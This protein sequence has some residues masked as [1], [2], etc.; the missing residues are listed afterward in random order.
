[1]I[2]SSYHKTGFRIA[3]S[4]YFVGQQDIEKKTSITKHCWPCTMLLFIR[5]IHIVLPYVGE[6]LLIC[7]WTLIKLQKRAVRQ[8]IGAGRY[9]HTKPIC[10]S[11][12]LPYLLKLC[13]YSVLIFL[14]KYH[15]QDLP[16]FFAD[17]FMA[18]D[19]FHE[20]DFR[21]RKQFRPPWARSNQRLL[22][23]V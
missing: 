8:I 20:H 9:D 21:Q 16:N 15:H 4:I 11:L 19:I 17:F 23:Y 1:M 22:C 18:N 10:Q 14:Y 6:H 7:S 13:T 12:N 2:I 3:A 5:S